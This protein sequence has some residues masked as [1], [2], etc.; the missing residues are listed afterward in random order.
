M[1]FNKNNANNLKSYFKLDNPL[2]DKDNSIKPSNPD[3]HTNRDDIY[4]PHEREMYQTR[5]GYRKPV[6]TSLHDSA[7]KHFSG[8]GKNNE[9]G[10]EDTEYDDMP[11]MPL[12]PGAL[13]YDDNGNYEPGRVDDYLEDLHK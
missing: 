9:W 2:P 5:P 3:I 11:N 6:S 1:S 7:Q 4:E 10:P 8:F 13:P 12:L